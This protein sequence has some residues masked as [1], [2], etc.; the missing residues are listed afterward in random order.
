MATN[1]RTK[2]AN[3]SFEKIGHIYALEDPSRGIVKVG[4][5]RNPVFRIST[6]R[7]THNAIGRAWISPVQWHAQSIEF[8]A[9]G[10]LAEFRSH[11][12]WFN[13]DFDSVVAACESVLSVSPTEQ[14]KEE[15]LRQSDERAEGLVTCMKEFISNGQ[16]NNSSCGEGAQREKEQIDEFMFK[17]RLLAPILGAV[18]NGSVSLC[19]TDELAFGEWL[20]DS[21]TVALIQSANKDG[22]ILRGCASGG[23]ISLVNLEIVARAAAW[24]SIAG[25]VMSDTDDD[26][27][28]IEGT[29]YRLDVDG[30]CLP[31]TP[32]ALKR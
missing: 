25:S 10:S 21:H 31:L 30:K 18:G 2:S 5:S 6:L 28:E 8:K 16:I 32:A 23:E 9:H 26:G 19:R 11:G 3:K 20:Q 29:E 17:S 12:E 15:S 22:S 7:A 13:L 27:E 4:F 1:T 14:E 24:A